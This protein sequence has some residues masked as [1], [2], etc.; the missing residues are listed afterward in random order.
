MWIFY[1]LEKRTKMA[2]TFIDDKMFAFPIIHCFVIN[3]MAIN[4]QK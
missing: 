4:S 3:L 1:E 2:D